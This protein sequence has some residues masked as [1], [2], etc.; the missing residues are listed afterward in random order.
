MPTPRP[1]A[2]AVGVLLAL[3]ACP[4]P[5]SAE[6]HFTVLAGLTFNGATNL[7]DPEFA[8]EDRHRSFGGI[9]SLLGEGILGAEVVASST[10][11]MFQGGLLTL[12]EITD[13]NANDVDLVERSRSYALMAN[14]MLTTPRRWTEY[15]LR[16]YVSSGFGVLRASHSNSLN[17]STLEVTLPAFN[18]GAGAIGFLSR[19]TGVRFD[20]RYF[21]TMQRTERIG[22]AFGPAY[23]GYMTASLGLVIR[24]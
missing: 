13:P 8:A 21:S 23:F 9:V 19:R 7:N 10:P 12:E 14:V 4:R 3:F 5:V 16:P 11:G 17:V 18:V 24:R 6:W 2:L 22:Q 15:G 1:G 20:V